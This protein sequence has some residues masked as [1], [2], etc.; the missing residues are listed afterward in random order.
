MKTKAKLSMFS[1]YVTF[2]ASW[3]YLHVGNLL[4]SRWKRAEEIY[5]ASLE[6]FHKLTESFDGENI[7]L[8]IY[9]AIVMHNHTFYYIIGGVVTE[10]TVQA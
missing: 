1:E 9:M 10:S 8:C 7:F 3:F 5:I 6:T 4:V 2:I